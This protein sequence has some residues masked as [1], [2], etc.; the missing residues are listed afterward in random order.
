MASPRSATRDGRGMLLVPGFVN[1]HYHSY[2]LL[3]KGLFEDVAGSAGLTD[4][5]Y[6]TERSAEHNLLR[7]GI[8]RERIHFVGRVPHDQVVSTSIAAFGRRPEVP[9]TVTVCTSLTP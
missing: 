6:T 8:A 7:E 4:L 2:D 9:P 3:A 1:S 5:L